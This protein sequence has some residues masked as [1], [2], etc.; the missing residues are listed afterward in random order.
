[1]TPAERQQCAVLGHF[2]GSS[3]VTGA[4]GL[5]CLLF[6][7]ALLLFGTLTGAARIV[8]SVV[9]VLGLLERYYALR[10]HFD[11]GL[12]RELARDVQLDLAALDGALAAL[13][14]RQRAATL[15]PLAERVRGTLRLFYLHCTCVLL[16][17]AGLIAARLL[18]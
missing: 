14:L 7:A 15:R 16:Q 9:V 8:A 10:L 1:M 5:L 17:V 13:G 12:F 11:V 2:I 3:R 6:A 4:L 18:A